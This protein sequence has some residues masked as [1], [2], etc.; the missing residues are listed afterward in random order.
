MTQKI[1]RSQWEQIRKRVQLA[2]FAFDPQWKCL[3][4]GL[5]WNKCREHDEDDM[6]DII[7][8]VRVKFGI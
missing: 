7:E 4:D 5:P 1:S 2:D 6:T 8:K 3:I